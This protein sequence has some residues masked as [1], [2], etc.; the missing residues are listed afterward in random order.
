MS[1]VLVYPMYNFNKHL[2]VVSKSECISLA[3]TATLYYN[4]V[5]LCMVT[6]A[7]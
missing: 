1:P 4:T 7:S 6:V 2:F 5:V 3:K